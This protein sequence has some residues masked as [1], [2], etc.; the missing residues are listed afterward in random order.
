MY[1]IK[2][3]YLSSKRQIKQVKNLSPSAPV[4]V[5]S[6]GLVRHEQKLVPPQ[7]FL[8]S[9]ICKRPELE[10]RRVRVGWYSRNKDLL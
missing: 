4:E 8:E 3:E 5:N 7:D 10:D 6:T 9:G 1:T 2:K